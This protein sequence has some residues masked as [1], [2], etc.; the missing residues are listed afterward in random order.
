VN[1]TLNSILNRRSIRLFKDEQLKLEDVDAIVEA[2]LY[3]P[4]ANNAQDW[5]FTVLQNKEMIE[6]VNKWLLDEVEI[7]ENHKLQEIV[8]RNGGRFFRNA[9]TIVIV[10]TEK[11]SRFAVVNAAAA[12]QNML[13]ASESLGIGSCWIGSVELLSISAHVDS[14]AKE[15]LLPEGYVPQFGITLGYGEGASP[16]APERKKDLVSYIF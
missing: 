14:F 9:P 6:K 16:I 13:I 12:T 5:H 15:L 8:K 11:K 1:D 4:S 7:S 2:G 3:G 10:S